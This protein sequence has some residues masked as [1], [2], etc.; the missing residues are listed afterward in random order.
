MPLT[1]LLAFGSVFWGCLPAKTPEP[2][3]GP[4]QRIER[5][6]HKLI[7]AEA[8]ARAIELRLSYEQNQVD[9]YSQLYDRDE[10]LVHQV[11][12]QI[13]SAKRLVE[14]YSS[15]VQ[16]ARHIVSY[17]AV[18]E[19]MN[20]NFTA[21][22]FAQLG[23][24]NA[25]AY[26]LR[27]GFLKAASWAQQDDI[28]AYERAETV[29]QVEQA[30]LKREEAH[31]EI[32]AAQAL[33]LSRQAQ[34]ETQLAQ[35]TL[36][37]V[38]GH[39]AVLIAADQARLEAEERAAALAALRRAQELAAARLRAEELAA[40]RAARLAAEERAAA[41]RR[42]A[43]QQQESQIV[44]AALKSTAQIATQA[45]PLAASSTTST[46]TTTEPSS[47]S[48]TTTTTPPAQSE[49]TSQA[50]PAVIGGASSS[51]G[52]SSGGGV[53]PP[54]P[55]AAI[56]VKTALAQ[57]GKPYVWGGAGPDVFDCSGLV[58]Y[59]W[60]AAG[61]YL[62]HFTVYQYNDTVRISPS[63]LEPGDLVFWDI[64]GDPPSDMPGHVAMYIGNGMVV[65]ADHTGA[66]VRVES[67]YHDG[68]P[69]GYGR[70]VASGSSG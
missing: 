3:P 58:M 14:Q 19:Y 16:K 27:L 37:Q 50:Q 69:M 23:S 65:A 35:Q 39:I 63:E 4:L 40:A 46:T 8:Q 2:R 29:L 48:D 42:A 60:A 55:G 25:S 68:I 54:L 5:H 44:E 56:A 70:V 17:M 59:A 33:R 24:S 51:S 30:R 12:V 6:D 15:Q 49:G 67:M 13:A 34:R 41:A 31:A 43:E 45:N 32:L 66:P 7:S 9:I 36:S 21:G 57:V 1:G 64:P 62:P 61:V 10:I 53:P 22:I 38:K 28:D 20:G 47:Q 18:E 11:S 26:E 52:S